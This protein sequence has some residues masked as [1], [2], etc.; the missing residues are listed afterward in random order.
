MPIIDKIA[1]ISCPT[2]DLD[3]AVEFY[4]HVLGFE[5]LFQRE[6]WAEFKVG[7]QRLALHQVSEISRSETAEGIRLSFLAKP[8][9]EVIGQLV[10]KGVHFVSRLQ[11]YPYGKLVSFE[12]PDGNILALYEPP[13]KKMQPPPPPDSNKE[14]AESEF[15]G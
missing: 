8:I 3:R 11:I 15:P 5:L 6:G 14:S 1:Y 9:H 7:G 4:E 2:K 13:S 12:D 10:N